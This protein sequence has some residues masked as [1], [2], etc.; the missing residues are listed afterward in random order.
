MFVRFLNPNTLVFITI[1]LFSPNFQA[2]VKNYVFE[3]GKYDTQMFWANHIG[4]KKLFYQTII[5][6]HWWYI[7]FE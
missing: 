7:L 2:V 1:K 6:A 3:A 4:N 5:K